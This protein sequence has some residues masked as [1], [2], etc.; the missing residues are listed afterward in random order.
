MFVKPLGYT[1]CVLADEMCFKGGR[2]NRLLKIDFKC[3]LIATELLQ[4]LVQLF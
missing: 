1:Q 3:Q 2:S 4:N